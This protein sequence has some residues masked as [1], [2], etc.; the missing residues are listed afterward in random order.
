MADATAGTS[1]VRRPWPTAAT[2]SNQVARLIVFVTAT[3]FFANGLQNLFGG[4]VMFLAWMAATGL[5]VVASTRI[6]KYFAE[7]R[8]VCR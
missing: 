5:V 8:R 4:F 2:R 7:R 3:Q 6:E 1:N